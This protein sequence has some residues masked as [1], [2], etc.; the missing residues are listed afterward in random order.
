VALPGLA[1]QRDELPSAR[2]EVG[3]KQVKQVCGLE[4]IELL[5]PAVELGHVQDELGFFLAALT[6]GAV[7]CWRQVQRM[8]P[9]VDRGLLHG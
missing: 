5:F 4:L 8:K 6:A 9:A 2:L 1:E 3:K 7:L